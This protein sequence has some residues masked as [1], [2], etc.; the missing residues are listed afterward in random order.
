MGGGSDGYRAA[1]DRGNQFVK[2]GQEEVGRLTKP[3]H[4]CVCES[5]CTV[6]ISHTHTFASGHS[7][8]ATTEVAAAKYATT[9]GE[10]TDMTPVR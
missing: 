5:V 2:L 1:R 10:G 8:G 7:N 6:Y 9:V 4:L 3:W